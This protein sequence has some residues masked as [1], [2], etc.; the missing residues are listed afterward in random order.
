MRK[1]GIL[2]LLIGLSLNSWSQQKDFLKIT[3]RKI[4]GQVLPSFYNKKAKN[5]SYKI[6]QTILL[7]LGMGQDSIAP[8]DLLN[9]WQTEVHF[10]DKNLLSFTLKDSNQIEKN[11]AFNSATG[12]LLSL[13]ELFTPSAL[14]LIKKEIVKNQN[15][16]LQN[17]KLPALSKQIEKCLKEDIGVFKLTADTVIIFSSHCSSID[18]L[19]VQTF[20]SMATGFSSQKLSSYLNV[21]G[22][23]LLGIIRKPKPK[24]FKSTGVAGYY[25]GEY[26][27]KEVYLLLENPVEKTLKGVFYFPGDKHSIPFSGT[28]KSNRFT[29][30]LNDAKLNVVISSGFF[31]GSIRR[32]SKD[33]IYL[34]LNKN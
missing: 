27:Q 7:A 33:I 30:V 25:E 20:Y 26:G 31:T 3:E 4:N 2:I 12:A 24:H 14:N 23:S 10:N 13:Q 5:A 32:S 19:G 16:L 8:D 21:Y 11:F 18:T 29:T 15:N 28:F 1:I 17:S 6:N 34:K 9:R 22:K